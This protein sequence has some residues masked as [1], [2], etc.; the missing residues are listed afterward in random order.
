M[1]SDPVVSWVFACGLLSLRVA[2]VFAFAPPFSLT[3]APPIFRAL[4]GVGIAICLVAGH[5]AQSRVSIELGPLVVAALRELMLGS[6]FVLAFQLTFAALQVAGRTID[7]QAGYGMA[8]VIDPATKAQSPLIGTLFSLLAGV[9]FFAADGAADLLRIFSAS[10]EVM[11]LGTASPPQ[12]LGPLTQ[13]MGLIWLTA[14][15]VG[16]GVILCLFLTDLAIAALARTVPQMN[17]LVLGFQVKAIVLLLV[18][19]VSLGFSASL[20]LRLVRMTLEGLP[21]L[22]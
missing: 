19:P 12:S 8:M 1:L 9:T 21:R 13:F 15:G 18:L 6:I 7:V 11:P 14:M 20:L 4:L 10:L 22:L 5:P 16:G 17:V 2:P 3:G